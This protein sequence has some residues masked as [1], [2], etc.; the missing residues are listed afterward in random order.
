MSDKPKQLLQEWD[1]QGTQIRMFTNEG[2]FVRIAVELP[3]A[4]NRRCRKRARTG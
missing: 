1:I 2:K 4:G 3:C